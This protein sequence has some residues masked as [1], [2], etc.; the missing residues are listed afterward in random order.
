M[1]ILLNLPVVA[2][3]LGTPYFGITANHLL[4]GPV[5]GTVTYLPAKFN[6]RVLDPVRFDVAPDQ[7]RYSK[8]QIMEESEAIRA[9][10]Q[11]ALHDM[12]RTRKSV[13]SG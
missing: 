1:P 5:L 4:F 2:K 11:E 10:I 13:W 12:L 3:L 6:L 8:S 9:T 7:P